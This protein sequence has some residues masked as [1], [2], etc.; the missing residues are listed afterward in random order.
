MKRDGQA[1]T[2]L[3]ALALSPAG[4]AMA[5]SGPDILL[6]DLCLNDRCRGVVPVAVENGRVLVDR[7]GLVAIGLRAD[8]AA[9]ERIGQRDFVAVAAAH[10]GA[11]TRIDRE[12]MR[13][14]ITV[15]PEFLP[16]QRI[17]PLP[18]PVV[19][20]A[21]PSWSGFLNYAASYGSTHFDRSLYLDGAV[22]RGHSALRSTALW[23][24]GRGWRRGLTRF[25]FDQVD[26]L[27]RWT[28][29][30]QFAGAGDPLGGGALIA[31]LGVERAFE[32]DPYLV[33]VPRPV[34]QGVLEAPGTVEVYAN[35]A[36]LTRRELAAGP[37]SLEGLGITP[38][39]NDVQ[40]IVR[41]PFGNRNEL[42]SAYFY[43]SNS[44]LA[45]GLS[46]YAA[47]IGLPRDGGLGG[48]YGEVPVWQGWYRRGISDHLTL[49]GRVEGHADL[50]N[51]G[52]DVTAGLG[53]GEISLGAARSDDDAAGRADAWSVDY[54]FAAPNWGVNLGAQRFDGN[55]RSLGQSLPL[56]DARLLSRDYANLSWSPIE[57]LHLQFNAGR[58]DR[59]T[60]GRD[61]H[62]GVSGT[63]QVSS[64]A[65][66]RFGLE[67][68]RYE[69]REDTIAQLGFSYSFEHAYL[70]VNL[71]RNGDSEGSGVDLRRSRPIGTGWGYDISV[72]RQDRFDTGFGQLE[73]QSEHGRYALQ[74][75][76]IDGHGSTRALASGALVAI[77]GRVFATPPLES[78]FALVRVPGQVG[79]PIQRH[80]H[81]IGRT[82][83]HGDLLVT[84]MI[85]HYP[86]KIAL[87]EAQVPMGYELL[88]EQ[89]EIA[90]PRNTGAVVTLETVA[91]RAVT[92][93]LRVR[94]GDAVAA[95]EYGVLRLPGVDG[96]HESL[97]G[98][99]GRFYFEQLPPG[100]HAGRLDGDAGRARCELEV[101]I[102]AVAGTVRLGGI[103]CIAEDGNEPVE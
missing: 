103:T 67:R 72:Q 39:R 90:V 78:G 4:V 94:R 28:L 99:D 5:Q 30:D 25:E 91:R 9:S 27:Q 68:R 41:D 86:N 92:G 31:G 35:G 81:E 38:G 98:G 69:D 22:G 49:G 54:A 34:Y 23:T 63:W 7:A 3:L 60:L 59:E 89:R 88:V 100:R 57:R 83:A 62:V 32:H 44:L 82:D 17:Q 37:F 51:R 20:H 2:I 8:G 96:G 52:F 15:A 18:A 76:R 36:L 29:G 21:G 6:L 56:L 75:D 46:D 16:A 47:R 13:L 97:V 1:R 58:A 77:G 80:N 48:S 84:G 24:Q 12:R 11:T 14:D 93:K 50:F 65:N 101:P 42:A 74:A 26:R 43:G 102:S 45:P 71:R 73:Y 55:Y 85:P 87:D 19:A 53:V 40:V 79:V 61:R 33:T 66:L 10:P 70:G 95:A 64:R